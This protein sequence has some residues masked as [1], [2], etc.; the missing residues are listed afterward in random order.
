MLSLAFLVG[1]DTHPDLRALKQA[2]PGLTGLATKTR[3][4][5]FVDQGAGDSSR[6]KIQAFIRH[7]GGQ[8]VALDGAA[9]GTAVSALVRQKTGADYVL[10]LTPDDRINRAGLTALETRLEQT[11]PDLVVLASAFWL[12]SADHPVPGPDAAR[13]HDRPETL[14]ADPRRLLRRGGGCD[15]P[16]P[17]ADPGTAWTLW[18]DMLAGA[19]SVLHLTDPVL[20]RPLPETGAAASFDAA[21]QRLAHM[22]GSARASGLDRL[23]PRLDDALRLA[24]AGAA[25]TTL[26]AA[27]RLL[28]TLPRG[29]RRRRLAGM[30]GPAARLLSALA[31]K[32]TGAALAGLALLAEAR[33]AQI[34]RAL[35]AE[36]AGLRHDLDLA[37]PGPDYL[38]ELYS[39]LR[40]V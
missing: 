9:P 16:D 23:L 14:F 1:A 40:G 31:R 7:N 13:D 35:A 17:L 2:L 20:L 19:G 25:E 8:L 22:S 32:E 37:L 11:E 38:M 6:E 4:L 15:H 28:A 36:Y 33:N 34:T 27:G 10:S 12:S 21:A 5:V 3:P 39:R 26:E 29:L 18:E 24:P 30:P